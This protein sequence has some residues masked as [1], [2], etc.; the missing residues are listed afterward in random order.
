MTSDL[1]EQFNVQYKSYDYDEKL[2]GEFPAVKKNEEETALIL[3]SSRE[4]VSYDS[5]MF[6][7]NS[8]RISYISD[9]HLMHR[10]KN[11]GCKSKEDV[12]YI[13]KK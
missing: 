8:N 3:Q 6:L 1:C 10:I 4:M 9:L 11:A 5:S 7:W 13:I 12:I 2:I